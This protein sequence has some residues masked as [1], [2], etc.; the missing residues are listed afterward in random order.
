MDAV[1]F[2]FCFILFE[3][4]K[5]IDYLFI[6]SRHEIKIKIVFKT[7]T[8]K[9]EQIMLLLIWGLNLHAIL[10]TLKRDTTYEY[11][12]NLKKKFFYL[13]FFNL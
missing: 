10:T 9:I 4:S 11:R 8:G 13:I 2:F 1:S 6:S 3:T 7:V 5:I 12:P